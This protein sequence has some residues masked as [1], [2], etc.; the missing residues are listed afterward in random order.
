MNGTPKDPKFSNFYQSS[1]LQ[2]KGELLFVVARALVVGAATYH[3]LS[4]F[5]C[6]TIMDSKLTR[7]NYSP[8]GYWK[9]FAAIKKLAEATKVP[10]DVA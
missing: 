7:V 10:E 4:T 3:F 2:K 9:G 5:Q 1:E 8:G 6:L